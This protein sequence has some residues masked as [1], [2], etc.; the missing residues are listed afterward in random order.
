MTSTINTST[1][2][3]MSSLSRNPFILAAENNLAVLLPLLRDDPTLASSQDEHGYSLVHAAAS[4]NHITLLRHLVQDFSVDVNALRD[5]DGETALFQTESVEVAKIMVEELGADIRIRNHEGLTA[6]EKLEDEGDSLVV[7]AYLRDISRRQRRRQGDDKH[8]RGNASGN[9]CNIEK[10][11]HGNN[12]SDDSYDDDDD[13]DPTRGMKTREMANE[14]VG[15]SILNPAPPLPP[16]I[17]IELLTIEQ[18][19]EPD[20]AGVDQGPVDD[21]RVNGVDSTVV[22]PEFKRRIEQL[23]SR[24]DIRDETGQ[25]ELRSLVTEALRQHV[26][27][28]NVTEGNTGGAVILPVSSAE[29]DGK[30]AHRRRM[31]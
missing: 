6:A 1:S 27:S 14:E 2:S 22:D 15:D 23:A 28:S 10:N 25:Q 17:S 12:D 7:A 20:E 4:Y 26:G 11:D 18:E 31:A 8:N 16:D 30:D 24:G 3:S 13:E 19:Q 9:G 29:E 21:Q 5:E